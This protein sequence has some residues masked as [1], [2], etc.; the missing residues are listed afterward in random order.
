MLLTEIMTLSAN[1]IIFYLAMLLPRSCLADIAQSNMRLS[2][3]NMQLSS[4]NMQLSS[5][6]M[7]LSLGNMQ[8][9][10]V[11]PVATPAPTVTA[12]SMSIT[13]AEAGALTAGVATQVLG[14]AIDLTVG[15]VS[16]AV[17]EAV[18][19][20]RPLT[21]TGENFEAVTTQLGNVKLLRGY[22]SGLKDSPITGGQGVDFPT[23]DITSPTP[24]EIP[25]IPTP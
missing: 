20:T 24:I 7:Q 11:A 5:G 14:A 22:I 3:G 25:V 17:D 21:I 2:S 13:G 1:I 6:N 4:G 16:E 8:V 9:L 10:N 18:G 23:L 15:Q 19:L 12:E